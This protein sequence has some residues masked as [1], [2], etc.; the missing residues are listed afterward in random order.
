MKRVFLVVSFIVL[1]FTYH[2]IAQEN[3]PKV[4][5]YKAPVYP[6]AALAVRAGGEVRLTLKLDQDGKVKST[7]PKGGHPL[8][9]KAAEIAALQWTFSPNLSEEQELDVCIVFIIGRKNKVKLKRPYRLEVTHRPP[10]IM[11]TRNRIVSSHS[12]TSF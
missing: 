9:R 4:L 5:S 10:K 8:L 2:S 6:A 7:E 11:Q 12:L 3:R 1:V